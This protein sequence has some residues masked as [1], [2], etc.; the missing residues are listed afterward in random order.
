MPAVCLGIFAMT[1]TRPQNETGKK[2]FSSLPDKY[3]NP[4]FLLPAHFF[5]GFLQLNFQHIHALTH[6]FFKCSALFLGA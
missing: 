1:H 4:D 3:T 5:F 6:G 2:T